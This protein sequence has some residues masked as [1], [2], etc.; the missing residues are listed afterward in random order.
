[1]SSAWFADREISR[2]IETAEADL[3]LACGRAVQRRR[4]GQ[5]VTTLPGSRS[6]ENAVRH[7]FSILY[8]RAVLRAP[9]L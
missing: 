7:D 5:T 6:E 3:T 1:M 9:P 8:A 2:R 4:P